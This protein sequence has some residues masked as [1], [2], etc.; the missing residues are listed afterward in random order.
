MCRC[1]EYKLSALQAV[2][3]RGKTP[4]STFRQSSW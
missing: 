2:G 4:H 1:N 3:D